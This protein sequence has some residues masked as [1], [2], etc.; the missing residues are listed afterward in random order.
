MLQG[1]D[2]RYFVFVSVIAAN[3]FEER[4]G[5]EKVLPFFSLDGNM[6]IFSCWD[7]E[8]AHPY[9]TIAEVAILGLT[10]PYRAGAYGWCLWTNQTRD[11]LSTTN[12]IAKVVVR[13]IA[14][15]NRKNST[16]Q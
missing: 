8:K 1:I 2:F 9:I 16:P 13:T 3:G 15:E 7:G 6:I 4:P 11:T 12:E 14:K 5:Q 10:N